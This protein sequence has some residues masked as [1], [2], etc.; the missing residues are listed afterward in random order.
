MTFSEKLATI[1]TLFLDT[2]PIIYY[3]EAHPQFGP[4]AKQAVEAFQTG[5][6]QAF[7]STITLAEVLPKPVELGDTALV[8]QFISLLRHGKNLRLLDITADIA[9]SAGKLR[10]KYL[11]LRTMDA[12]QIAT[13][14]S[15]GADAFMTND[16]RLKSVTEIDVFVLKDYIL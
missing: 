5:N 8:D 6:V 13:A 14:L 1:H 11:T 4:L 16:R 7:S 12:L 3:I 2:A 9:E 15:T 10:G